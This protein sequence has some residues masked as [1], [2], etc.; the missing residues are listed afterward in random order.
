MTYEISKVV[1]VTCDRCGITD[2]FMFENA[3]S[4]AYILEYLRHVERWTMGR[5]DCLCPKCSGIMEA[6]E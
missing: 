4:R 5:R 2:T 1:E 6:V 3:A